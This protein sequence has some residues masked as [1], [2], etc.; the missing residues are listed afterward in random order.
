MAERFSKFRKKQVIHI[1]A[2][3]RLGY[4]EDLLF[5]TGT[6]QICA[7]IVPGKAR[8]FGLFGREDD[9]VIPWECI[10][11]IGEDVVLVD[12]NSELWRKPPRKNSI[13]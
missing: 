8:F 6:G 7:I 10:R 2:G 9:Y 3:C 5:E 13:F 12:G 1:C 11:R 4:A